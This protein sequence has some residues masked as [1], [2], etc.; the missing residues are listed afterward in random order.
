MNLMCVAS[1]QTLTVLVLLFLS[2][3]TF[4]FRS[5]FVAWFTFPFRNET[6]SAH[7]QDVITTHTFNH[8][9]PSQKMESTQN[10]S[11]LERDADDVRLWLTSPLR[12]SVSPAAP[13][14][15]Q[16]R[17]REPSPAESGGAEGGTCRQESHAG[18]AH[19]INSTE[20]MEST[21]SLSAEEEVR[22]WLTSPLRNSISP[23]ALRLLQAKAAIKEPLP[24]CGAQTD[25]TDDPESA[26]TSARN[27]LELIASVTSHDMARLFQEGQKGMR[28]FSNEFIAKQRRTFFARQAEERR[29]LDEVAQ[30]GARGDVEAERLACLAALVALEQREQR[31]VRIAK[32]VQADIFLPLS[33]AV[34]A[35][36]EMVELQI[37]TDPV[38]TETAADYRRLHMPFVTMLMRVHDEQAELQEKGPSPT[39]PPSS[40]VSLPLL[41]EASD[42]SLQL[43]A[44]SAARA[45][46]EEAESLRRQ[47]DARVID[48]SL[49]RVVEQCEAEIRLL[50]GKAEAAHISAMQCT[51]MRRERARQQ[52]VIGELHLQLDDAAAEMARKED[53]VARA[54]VFAAM[55]VAR[56]ETI[57]EQAEEELKS[58]TVHGVLATILTAVEA[59]VAA[60]EQAAAEAAAERRA[61][62][63]AEN[64]RRGEAQRV[65][66]EAAERARLCEDTDVN[67]GTMARMV[68]LSPQAEA[69]PQQRNVSPVPRRP[70]PPFVDCFNY[71]TPPGSDRHY[72]AEQQ[73]R[74]Q[75]VATSPRRR[76]PMRT[77]IS[78]L[79]NDVLCD[80]VA[81][82]TSNDNNTNSTADDDSAATLQMRTVQEREKRKRNVRQEAEASHQPQPAPQHKTV[83]RT[84]DTLP[85]FVPTPTSNRQSHHHDH[86]HI[87]RHTY[88]PRASSTA[89][90]TSS[91][92]SS[93]A[94]SRR[95]SLL[96]ATAP[97]QQQNFTA[98]SPAVMQLASQVTSLAEALA[99]VEHLLASPPGHQQRP[100][101]LDSSKPHAVASSFPTVLPSPP[102]SGSSSLREK[103]Q[104]PQPQ[105]PPPASHASSSTHAAAS[106]AASASPLVAVCNGSNNNSRCNSA[107]STASSKTSSNGGNRTAPAW[108]AQALQMDE[109]KLRAE[110]EADQLAGSA[111][112]RRE[113]QF[114][115][116][117]SHVSRALSCFGVAVP[118]VHKQQ[119][120][121][122]PEQQRWR[123]N[124]RPSPP[125]CPPPPLSASRAAL[126]DTPRF[127]TAAEHSTGSGIAPFSFHSP[128][129]ATDIVTPRRGLTDI[130]GY[131]QQQQQLHHQHRQR[132]IDIFV[133]QANNLAAV[134]RSS[135]AARA[136]S[137]PFTVSSARVLI[138][139]LRGS[140]SMMSPGAMGGSAAAAAAPMMALAA[141]A[142]G[143]AAAGAPVFRSSPSITAATSCDS[144]S[145][146]MIY[147]CRAGNCGV[148]M[149]CF[150]GRGMSNK[151]NNSPGGAAAAAA[152]QYHS[153][154]VHTTTTP[155]IASPT[156]GM[157]SASVGV[158]YHT[159]EARIRARKARD[160]LDASLL[161]HSEG[162]LG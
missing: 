91:S 125:A 25:Q 110:T 53:A 120:M 42:L 84:R 137:D 98:P 158:G 29:Q 20:M 143:G 99:R 108:A 55:Q 1:A 77:I 67:K 92:S 36:A 57:R 76:E 14:L 89:A 112:L 41:L 111:H 157:V 72:H 68:I 141:A 16:A 139:N 118:V 26:E 54:E 15:L 114:A 79:Q 17:T 65:Y 70:S 61:R 39:S 47:G 19:N 105:R 155:I 71:V 43:R 107:S 152:A 123:N 56:A 37:Q 134:R 145:P 132:H 93:V 78:P 44:L 27:L 51:S 8:P 59:T 87:H 81:A 46:A 115:A 74:L 159:S 34:A 5:L 156:T 95:S 102:A 117:D 7:R 45:A 13:R 124:R 18:N 147:S 148:C 133:P 88:A 151:I 31:R 62:H 21:F 149:C 6:P 58:A 101:E 73:Q 32:S 144:A 38:E 35:V 130:L 48:S 146:P 64:A 160:L 135:S 104:Q 153:L 52:R 129:S 22:L 126:V 116:V 63:A 60:R 11:S 12:N 121:P 154:P 28:M 80:S 142:V 100:A 131:S 103:Q 128:P 2:D 140:G 109:E 23:A 83:P 9:T 85:C 30:G 94:S 90:V 136:A 86:H 49:R 161:G 82:T 138:Q 106:A 24:E 150:R 113:F 69:R 122:T 97:S 66:A 4:L 162:M 3:T 75:A 127:D 119:P 40:A 10:S 96:S 33:V 50:R